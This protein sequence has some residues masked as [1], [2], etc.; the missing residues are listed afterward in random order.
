MS[1]EWRGQRGAISG[2]NV[3]K[4]CTFISKEP[5][6]SFLQPTP[7]IFWAAMLC[8]LHI[9]SLHRKWALLKWTYT[10][11]DRNE[12]RKLSLWIFGLSSSTT[13][14][15]CEKEYS[16]QDDSIGRRVECFQSNSFAILFH[17]PHGQ[18]L[19]KS[20]G[21]WGGICKDPQ[22]FPMKRQLLHWSYNQSTEDRRNNSR[23]KREFSGTWESFYRQALDNPER[24][25]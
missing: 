23:D 18:Y 17:F 2:M 7:K 13:S 15:E 4:L 8:W 21:Q 14:T 24:E 9:D 5:T 12:F 16:F 10:Y 11:R 19:R 6:L 3:A 20:S 1:C 25:T 22:P